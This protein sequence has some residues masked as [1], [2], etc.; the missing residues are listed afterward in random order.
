M[1]NEPRSTND[2]DPWDG[3]EQISGGEDTTDTKPRNIPP[4]IILFKTLVNLFFPLPS[5][6]YEWYKKTKNPD[7]T[8]G[9]GEE[10]IKP[11]ELHARNTQFMAV[12]TLGMIIGL[13][14]DFKNTFRFDSTFSGYFQENLNLGSL[15]GSFEL[16]TALLYFALI[17]VASHITDG[18]VTYVTA[19]SSGIPTF[20]KNAGK[21]AIKHTIFGSSFPWEPKN[22]Y[23]PFAGP[24]IPK[25]DTQRKR[26]DS[27]VAI[28]SDDPDAR[29][30]YDYDYDNTPVS[31]S[32]ATGGDLSRTPTPPS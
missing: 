11:T 22:L 9:S 24:Q 15:T 20:E 5:E 27:S 10:T 4:H 32:K 6:A 23:A 13:S 30:D 26:S 28:D 3:I 16:D 14:S 8:N 29:Y 31:D 12:V 19:K 1:A 17:T 7:S 18:L 25:P 2:E 21:I